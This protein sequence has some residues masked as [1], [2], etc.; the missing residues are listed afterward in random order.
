MV[1]ASLSHWMDRE[2]S[3][4]AMKRLLEITEF[5]RDESKGLSA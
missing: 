2:F 4:R 1:G 3:K 5:S